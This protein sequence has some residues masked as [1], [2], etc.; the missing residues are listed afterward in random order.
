[1]VTAL[2]RSDQLL[3]S[4]LRRRPRA[5]VSELARR[6]SLARGTIRTRLDRLEARDVIRGYGPDV[7][8]SAAGFDVRAFTTLSIAQ[9]RHDPTVARLKMIPE[10]VEIHTVTGAGDLLLRI[11][12]TTNDHLHEVLQRVA[13]L[14][15][16]DRT[17]T[18]LALATPLQR[19]VADLI[20]HELDRSS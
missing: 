14:P 5:S 20:A 10:V 15:D 11:V 13:S 3:I 2:D 8:A 6:L 19:T 7:D 18:Q 1:L 4:A 12:A 17:E 16:V 9:G